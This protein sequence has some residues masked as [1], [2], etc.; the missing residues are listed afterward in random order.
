MIASSSSRWIATNGGDAVTAS[1]VLVVATHPG[2]ED[3]QWTS[4]QPFPVVVMTKKAELGSVEH[5]V[6]F[7]KA[8]EA[9]CYLKFILDHYEDLPA[10]MIFSHNHERSWHIP[11]VR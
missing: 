9:E 7:N 10:R 8:Q 2:G 4:R 3:V 5:N 6:P 11:G 1:T